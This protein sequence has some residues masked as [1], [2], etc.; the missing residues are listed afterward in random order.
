LKGIPAT[1]RINKKTS[2]GRLLNTK[3][4]KKKGHQRERNGKHHDG[5]KRQPE[6]IRQIIHQQEHEEKE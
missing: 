5:P 6:I 4:H 2:T 1:R 3:H